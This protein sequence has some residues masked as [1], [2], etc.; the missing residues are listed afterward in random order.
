MYSLMCYCIGHRA[1][2]Q[3][4]TG[5][6]ER[7]AAQ[8]LAVHPQDL[9][10]LYGYGRF[11]FGTYGPERLKHYG[12]MLPNLSNHLASLQA[13]PYGISQEVNGT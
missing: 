8:L 11:E 12:M 5:T 7:L 1:G 3:D 4:I 6:C 9:K 2:Q 10:I 13:I